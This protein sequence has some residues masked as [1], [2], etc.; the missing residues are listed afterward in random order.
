[1]QSPDRQENMKWSNFLVSLA[2]ICFTTICGFAQTDIN[3]GK[4]YTINSEV[5]EQERKI[6]VYLPAGYQDSKQEYPVLYILDGQWFFTNGVAIQHSLRAPSRLPEMI[7]VGIQNQNPLRRTLFWEERGQFLSFLE[8]EV[9]AFIHKNFRAS[10]DRIL[11]GWEAGAAFACYAILHPKSLFS[12][13]IVTNG[14]YADE[15]MVD[16]F[17]R[18]KTPSPKNLFIA[19]SRKDIYSIDNSTSMVDLLTEKG[20]SHLTWEYREF[21]NEV[22]ESLPFLALYHGLNHYYHNYK[23]LVFGS[24][25]EYND[26]GGLTYLKDY[27]QKRGERFGFPTDIDDSAKNSLI[28]LAWKRDNFEAFALFMTEFEDVLSTRRYDSA[29]WQNRF[30]QFYLKHN[31]LERA[32]YF[33]NQGISKYP[34]ASR[35]A[36]MHHGLGKTYLKKKDKKRALQHFEKAVSL[37]E[38]IKDP[39][40]ET[41]KEELLRLKG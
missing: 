21:N 34:E 36:V 22:H 13:A 39:A 20:L 38:K 18:L 27:Y 28:W 1:M 19:N 2:L 11:F 37:G 33:F 31:D 9:N 12:A 29:Y 35:I 15:E 40:L 14:A 32:I 17:S 8:I 6:Q 4:S 30:A 16:A 5:L 23:S 10:T 41:Y 26:L 7:V 25:Q 3:I 24:I